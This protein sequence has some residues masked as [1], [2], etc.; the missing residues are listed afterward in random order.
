MSQKLPPLSWLRAF[1]SAARHLSFTHAAAELGLTQAAISKQIKL[2]ELHLREPLFDRR[3]RSL[4]LTKVAAAYLPKVKD[5]FERLSAGTEEVF[6]N[7]SSEVLTI[8]VPVGLGVLWLAER[9]PRFF[10]QHPKVPLRIVSSVWNEEFDRERYDLDIRY[11]LGQWPGFG[12]DR[13]SWEVW[14]PICLPACAARLR[15]PDDLA[16]EPLLHVIGYQEGWATWLAA[17]EAKGVNSGAGMQVDTSIL[18]YELA[19]QGLGVAL[20]RSSMA[21]KDLASGRLVRPFDLAVPAREAFYLLSPEAG[22][23]HPD[24]ALFRHWLV[25]EADAGR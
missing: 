6:G 16:R 17:A 13:L 25:A 20:G 9:L 24:A 15:T 18:A 1:E 19:A 5:A 11:G 4:A 3:P 22:L 14:E 12:S 23:L 7:R 10:A 21:A 8:R 2:L